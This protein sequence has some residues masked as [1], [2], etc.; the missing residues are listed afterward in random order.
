MTASV[1]SSTQVTNALA[2]PP[3]YVDIAQ[4]GNG[5]NSTIM[6]TIEVATTS[7]DDVG[8][9]VVLAEVRGSDRIRSIRVFND[10]LDAHAT[11]TLA[12]DVGLYK[13][14]TAAGTGATVVDADAYASAITTLQAANSSGV[15]VMCEARDIAKIGKADQT[16]AVDG[17]ES[18]HDDKRYIAMTVTATAATAAAGTVSFIIDI[19]RG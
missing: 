17:G 5:R 19:V 15:E 2:T 13:S 16:V 4:S 1:V 14:V 12:V 7:I 8:D 11:P 9:I 3:T 6:G 10:D 18:A